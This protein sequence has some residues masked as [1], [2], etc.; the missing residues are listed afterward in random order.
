LNP[1]GPGDLAPALLRGWL[2]AESGQLRLGAVSFRLERSL[3][4]R[5]RAP[6]QA[7]RSRGVGYL[8]AGGWGLPGRAASCD[9]HL[10]AL[11]R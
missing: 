8:P 1:Q 3:P 11:V 6:R 4:G 2:G 5:C 7:D 9:F 10:E